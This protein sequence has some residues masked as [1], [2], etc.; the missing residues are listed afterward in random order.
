MGVTMTAT[1]KWYMAFTYSHSSAKDNHWSPACA[2]LRPQYTFCPYSSSYRYNRRHVLETR[3]CYA[4]Q[5][6][7]VLTK[8]RVPKRVHWQVTKRW[9]KS[10][11]KIRLQRN[12]QVSSGALSWHPY[13]HWTSNGG[14][15]LAAST[16]PR[17]WTKVSRVELV[18]WQKLDRGSE[19]PW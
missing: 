19:V 3:L 15:K 8:Y 4:V 14:R 5:S 13:P 11:Y 16:Q 7:L 9:Y 6:D 2:H 10:L 17:I 12:L 18:S 1:V